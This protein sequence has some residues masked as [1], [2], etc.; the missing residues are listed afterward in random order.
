MHQP[1]FVCVSQL[2]PR[3]R[4]QTKSQ[5]SPELTS[6]AWIQSL[7]NKIW[8][9][10]FPCTT[11]VS[12]IQIL[13]FCCCQ[14]TFSCLWSLFPSFLPCFLPSFL[15]SFFSSFFLTSFFLSFLHSFLPSFF[16]C[17]SPF[18]LFPCSLTSFPS[19]VPFL[20]YLSLFCFR[21]FFPAFLCSFF[22][23]SAYSFV[24]ISFSF[25]CRRFV[26][27]YVVIST[28]E[29]LVLQWA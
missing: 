24:N 29:L 13:N 12:R 20:F 10:E 21:L 7:R 3:S 18:S 2:K 5:K 15:P 27:L 4:D 22:L 17:C 1:H 8:D 23:S 16:S 28:E 25:S 11:F 9:T 26:S 14:L 19:L 6:H